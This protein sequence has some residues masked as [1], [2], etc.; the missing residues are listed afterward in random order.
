LHAGRK[1]FL[2]AVE[3]DLQRLAEHQNIATVLHRHGQTD[4]VFRH[5][6]HAWRRG[7]VETA[8]HVG[9][10]GD[11]ERTIAHPNREVFDL[12]DRLKIPRDP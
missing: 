5:K 12:L 6:A 3:L 1:V 7:I 9:D 11:A 10:I 2:D 8:T 4:G